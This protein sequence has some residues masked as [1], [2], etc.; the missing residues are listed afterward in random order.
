MI[1]VG[2]KGFGVQAFVSMGSE[3]LGLIGFEIGII[4]FWDLGLGFW[5]LSGRRVA[6]P[7]H[8]WGG[9]GDDPKI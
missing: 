9:A 3:A 8:L 1:I 7:A 2:L 4:G 5:R 6:G